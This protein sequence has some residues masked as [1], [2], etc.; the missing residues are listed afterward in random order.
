MVDKDGGMKK[1]LHKDEVHPTN[2]GYDI[3][4]SVVL[5]VLK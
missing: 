1:G 2:A 4:E 5:K 3:M